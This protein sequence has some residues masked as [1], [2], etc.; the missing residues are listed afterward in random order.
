MLITDF[1]LH[2]WFLS[3]SPQNFFFPVLSIKSKYHCV[4][5][6]IH[7]Y[8]SLTFQNHFFLNMVLKINVF[9]FILFLYS[10]HYFTPSSPLGLPGWLSIPTL[11][12]F[13]WA[14]WLQT[15]LLLPRFC[16]PFSYT[17]SCLISFLGRILCFLD[18]PGFH[19]SWFMLSF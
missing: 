9:H 18:P 1:L 4:Y 5:I 14:L 3:L 17:G 6:H 8:Y 19:H 10:C 12:F 11:Y 15:E 7:F 16:L 2:Q 13:P